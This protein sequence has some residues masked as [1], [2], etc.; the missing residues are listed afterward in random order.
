MPRPATKLLSARELEVALEDV[1]VANKACALAAKLMVP[2]SVACVVYVKVIVPEAPEGRLNRMPVVALSACVTVPVLD[3]A[4]E[5]GL[6]TTL[7]WVA[8]E[9]FWTV[10][11][12]LKLL[13]APRAVTGVPA[14]SV[15]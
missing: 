14:V 9:L 11:T 6:A 10:I 1:A 5:T 8:L 7:F 13:P 15:I 2:L 12:S 3:A 4:G